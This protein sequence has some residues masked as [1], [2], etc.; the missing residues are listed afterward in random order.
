MSRPLRIIIS[1]WPTRTRSPRRRPR[2]RLHRTP[3]PQSLRNRQSLRRRKRFHRGDFAENVIEQQPPFGAERDPRALARQVTGGDEPIEPS[4]VD[5][6]NTETL[7]YR[8][9][10]DAFAEP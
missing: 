4:P 6:C 9:N 5:H 2:E 10:I 7:G 8:T 1:S 3:P